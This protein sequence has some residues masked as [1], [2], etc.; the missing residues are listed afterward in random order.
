MEQRAHFYTGL[1]TGSASCGATFPYCRMFSPI[2][3]GCG[4]I[5][6]VKRATPSC[7]AL[8]LSPVDFVPCVIC[9]RPR[10]PQSLWKREIVLKNII[11]EEI[12][13]EMCKLWE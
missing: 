8:H 12:T 6:P 5:V 11:E 1:K 4:T 9:S 13:Y 2:L 7:G 3:K 10:K